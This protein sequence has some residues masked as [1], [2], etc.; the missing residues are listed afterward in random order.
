MPST[1]TEM[2]PIAIA[3]K[4]SATLALSIVKH[5]DATNTSRVLIVAVFSAPLRHL[6][7]VELPDDA[8]FIE[9]T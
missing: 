5:K 2:C 3:A 4:G 9:K 7:E 8:V 6:D 1:A